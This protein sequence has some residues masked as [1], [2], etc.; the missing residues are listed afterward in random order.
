M[1][2]VSSHCC[3]ELRPW[4]IDHIASRGYVMRKRMRIIINVQ[5]WLPWFLTITIIRSRVAA[6]ASK[7]RFRRPINRN[8]RQIWTQRG[9]KPLWAQHLCSSPSGKP[10]N[11]WRDKR[12]HWHCSIIIEDFAKAHSY[13]R[14]VQRI[15]YTWTTI[16]NFLCFFRS[17]FMQ[18]YLSTISNSLSQYFS[19]IVQL[20]GIG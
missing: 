8:R 9:R 11:V 17:F 20:S 5:K 16:R 3:E 13:A 10:K 14:M 15:Q 6:H 12:T 2:I 7:S 1:R 18:A 4:R 19:W